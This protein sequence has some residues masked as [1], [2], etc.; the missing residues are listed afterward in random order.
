MKRLLP[1]L[2]ATLLFPIVAAHPADYPRVENLQLA[3]GNQRIDIAWDAIPPTAEVVGYAVLVY[4][5]GEFVQRINTTETRATFLGAINGR[6]YVVEVVAVDAADRQGPPAVATTQPRFEADL[7]YLALGL[8]VVWIGLWGYAV[9]L[10]RR[11][12]DL[13]ARLERIHD[14]K[15]RLGNRP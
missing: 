6:T 11:S 7:T 12:R 1:L 14:E 2:A 13:A 8:A 10:A 5:E 9:M 15:E 4:S 3:P